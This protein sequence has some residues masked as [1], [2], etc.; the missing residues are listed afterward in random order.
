MKHNHNVASADTAGEVKER[1]WYEPYGTPTNRRASDG[2][3]TTSSHFSNPCL[4]TARR[5]DS[6]TGVYH[7]RNRCY[8]GKLGRFMGRD[9]IGFGAADANL[10]RYVDYRMIYGNFSADSQMVDLYH[11]AHRQ[12]FS[13][14]SRLALPDRCQRGHQQ[15]RGRPPIL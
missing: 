14:S 8:S 3:E 9:P 12:S 2:D 11:R 1:A 6:E 10:Y 7:Y 5:L 4:F 13:S 15:A